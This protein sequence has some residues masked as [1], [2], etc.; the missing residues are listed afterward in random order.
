MIL[1]VAKCPAKGRETP[2]KRTGNHVCMSLSCPEPKSRAGPRRGFALLSGVFLVQPDFSTKS[3][4]NRVPWRPQDPILTKKL[5]GVI[6]STLYCRLLTLDRQDDSR[7]WRCPS[8]SCR[9]L[10][11]YW[12]ILEVSKT[13]IEN[14]RPASP[15]ARHSALSGQDLPNF[16]ITLQ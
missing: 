15:K 5:V 7:S 11:V 16:G 14:V 4:Q 2:P 10:E 6:R 13:P 3:A 12:R 9:I 8:A 1:H